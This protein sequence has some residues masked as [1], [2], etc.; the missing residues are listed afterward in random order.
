MNQFFYIIHPSLKISLSLGSPQKG[1]LTRKLALASAC[2]L[3]VLI[4][5]VTVTEITR[6]SN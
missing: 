1:R 5:L 6:G 4:A 3:Q 2:K